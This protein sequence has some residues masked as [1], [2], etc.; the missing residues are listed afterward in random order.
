[1]ASTSFVNLS[2]LSSTLRFSAMTAVYHKQWPFSGTAARAQDKKVSDLRKIYLDGKLMGEVPQP[3]D[4]EQDQ[5]LAIALLREKGLYQ[6]PTREQAMFWH[7]VAFATTASYLYKRDLTTV[8]R[9]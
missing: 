3:G 1:I 4:T 5:K 9:T 7:A 8:P 2:I 6:K